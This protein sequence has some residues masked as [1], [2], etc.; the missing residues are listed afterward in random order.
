M[1]KMTFDKGADFWYA[2]YYEDADFRLA[3]KQLADKFGSFFCD[4]INSTQIKGELCKSLYSIMSDNYNAFN[5]VDKFDYACFEDGEIVYSSKH[6]YITFPDFRIKPLDELVL[7][8]DISPCVGEEDSMTKIYC[9]PRYRGQIKASDIGD[10][11]K[12]SELVCEAA[13]CILSEIYINTFRNFAKT[14][15]LKIENNDAWMKAPYLLVSR[16]VGS[17]DAHTKEFLRL[18]DKPTEWE[19]FCHNNE[20]GKTILDVLS[21]M[22][23][24][25]SKG[26]NLPDYEWFKQTVQF[27]ST[28]PTVGKK[29]DREAIGYFGFKADEHF[30][31]CIGIADSYPRDILRPIHRDVIK[32]KSLR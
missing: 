8:V 10:F 26:W 7:R 1:E 29:L 28:D 27:E 30:G 2:H 9:I 13:I 31:H 21:E 24:A 14:A 16:M 20:R 17:K 19:E 15:N 25:N 11:F 18:L 23:R 5:N 22:N 3:D 12:R 6:Q 32:T 4:K